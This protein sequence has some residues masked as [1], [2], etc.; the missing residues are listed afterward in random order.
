[1]FQIETLKQLV[2]RTRRSFRTHLPGS[3]AWVWP[4]NIGPT[5]KV[6]GG[7]IHELFGFADYIRR[8]IFVMSA[9]SESLDLHGE[10]YGLARRP[11]GPA[12]GVVSISS[13]LGISIVVGARFQRSDGFVYIATNGG[14]QTGGGVV[15][16]SVVAST[17]G[18]AGNAIAGTP[19]DIL[20]GVTGDDEAIASIGSAGVTLGGDI[21]GDEP[22]RGRIL[23]RK[24][25]PPHGGSA[26]DYVMWTQEVSGVTR[27]F[28][29]PLW[30]GAGTVRVYPLMDDLYSDGIPQGA[31]VARVSDYI[32]ALKPAG[33]SVLVSAPNAVPINITIS[34]LQPFTTSVKEAV[35]TELR[36]AFHLQS[37]VAG[38]AKD[39][40]SL[41]YLA[42]PTTFSRSWIWQA[43]A[44]ASGE[45]RH[46]ITSPSADTALAAGEIA[47]LGAVTFV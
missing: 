29:E 44:N 17:D 24:R 16:I 9:D 3:D 2:E 1:M 47:T 38:G 37:R 18:K 6:F 34:G 15:D 14:S 7:L 30:A 5:A 20:S 22:F 35:L 46:S 42:R 8:Q 12:S 39:I 32:D 4:N 40:A 43:V 45:Q 31:D 41:P 28:V 21:E 11:A 10:E 13:A 27:V 33:A 25:N 36:A 26:A 19:L 23:F